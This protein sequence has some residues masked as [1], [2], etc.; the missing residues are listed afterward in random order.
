MIS[1]DVRCS[2]GS[3]EMIFGSFFVEAI[4]I[5][6]IVFSIIISTKISSGKYLR[7]KSETTQ[8]WSTWY[9]HTYYQDDFMLN[10]CDSGPDQR[11][12]WHNNILRIANLLLWM[13][14]LDQSHKSFPW[15]WENHLQP[16]LLALLACPFFLFLV[17]IIFILVNQYDK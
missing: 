14:T 2:W 16:Y 11:R 9:N 3:F 5:H 8:K 10:Y 7:K 13:G 17:S 4:T 1:I 12:P 15:Q 6:L